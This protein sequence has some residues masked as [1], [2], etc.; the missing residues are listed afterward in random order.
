MFVELGCLTECSIG[1]D[2]DNGGHREASFGGQLLSD[3]VGWLND[4]VNGFVLWNTYW[5][6]NKFLDLTVR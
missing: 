3:L 4:I 1:H 5:Y 6:S 2:G